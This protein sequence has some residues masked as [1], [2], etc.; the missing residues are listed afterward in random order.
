[1]IFITTGGRIRQFLACQG[2]RQFFVVK[3]GASNQKKVENTG[4]CT[5][6]FWLGKD[7]QTQIDEGR[8]WT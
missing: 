2:C 6:L 3:R 8:I 4:V 5:R 1:M 7:Y